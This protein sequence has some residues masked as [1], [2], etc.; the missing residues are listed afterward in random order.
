MLGIYIPGPKEGNKKEEDGYDS[1][2]SFTMGVFSFL[3]FNS[4]IVL[5]YFT[6]K[7]VGLFLFH[8]GLGNVY[9]PVLE[10]KCGKKEN[11]GGKR[12]LWNDLYFFFSLPD[13]PTVSKCPSPDWI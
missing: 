9:K 10:Q 6:L 13:S 2:S 3:F 5:F 4:Y 11:T 12:D 1:S 8:L 7:A